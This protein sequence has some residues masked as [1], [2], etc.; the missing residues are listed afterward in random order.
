M[1]GKTECKRRR[2]KQRMRYGF[3]GLR[4]MNFSKLLE[5]VKNRGVWCAGV[6]GDAK[7]GK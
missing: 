4:D 3:T 7:S 5:R 1:L 2:G 6:H